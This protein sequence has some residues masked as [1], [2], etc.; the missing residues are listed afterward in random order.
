MRRTPLQ[1]PLGVARLTGDHLASI[2]LSQNGNYL[3]IKFYPGTTGTTPAY[4]AAFALYSVDRTKLTATHLASQQQT[5]TRTDV[6]ASLEYSSI[7]F[8]GNNA[9]MLYASYYINGARRLT[10][11]STGKYQWYDSSWIETNTGPLASNYA[12]Y[13]FPPYIFDDSNEIEFLFM[14]EDATATNLDIYPGVISSSANS[15]LSLGKLATVAF[16]Y[17]YYIFGTRL[18]YGGASPNLAIIN[19]NYTVP[20]ESSSAMGY[21]TVPTSGSG[22]PALHSF[23]FSNLVSNPYADVPNS[24]ETSWKNGYFIWQGGPVIPSAMGN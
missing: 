9:L 20:M 2:S 6:G 14:A 3:G 1:F 21:L 23:S 13:A 16:Q 24:T 18:G 12:Y 8:N 5:Q 15:S 17:P 4:Q 19:G 11:D 22:S 10:Q 7:A